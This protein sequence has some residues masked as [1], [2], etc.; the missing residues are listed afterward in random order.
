MLPSADGQ[1]IKGAMQVTKMQGAAL[2][3]A[4]PFIPQADRRH[5]S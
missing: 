5:W 3:N 4:I 1:S 2:L